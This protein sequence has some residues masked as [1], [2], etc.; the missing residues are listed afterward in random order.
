MNVIRLLR[1]VLAGAI[2]RVTRAVHSIARASVES[3]SA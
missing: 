3:G 1:R 2:T